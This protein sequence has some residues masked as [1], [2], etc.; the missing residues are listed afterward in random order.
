MSPILQLVTTVVHRSAVW[1][2]VFAFILA[3]QSSLF[4]AQCGGL[5]KDWKA[6]PVPLAGP[7]TPLLNAPVYGVFPSQPRMPD[8]E[9]RVPCRCTGTSCSPAAPTPVP[10]Q[11]VMSGQSQEAS[12]ER[13][14]QMRQPPSVL[15]YSQ[16]VQGVRRYEVVLGLL[17]PPCG[18]NAE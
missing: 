17:R 15:V 3:T 1:G 5:P 6:N 12:V 7:P 4:A 16:D 2:I 18:V 10:D 14:A 9:R 8:P 13:F 11:R